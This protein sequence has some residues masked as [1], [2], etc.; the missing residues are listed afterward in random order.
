[1]AQEEVASVAVSDADLAEIYVDLHAHPEVSFQEERTAQIV[2]DR[3][4]E[5]GYEVTTGVGGTG[6]VG[7]LDNG[8]GPT[9]LLHADM[10]G[11]PMAEKTG[12]DYA[13]P[14]RA[15]DRLGNDV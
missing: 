1:M 10:G 6:V 11:L 3:L 13:S 15:V 8:T 5:W 12:L 4:R 2:A 7:I 14:Q 9:V